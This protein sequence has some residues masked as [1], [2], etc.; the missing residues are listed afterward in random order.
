MPMGPAA[1]V[2]DLVAHA[3]PPVLTG[4]PGST[5]VLIGNQPAW[6]GLTAAGAAALAKAAAEL[7]KDL[8]K[9]L[10]SAAAGNAKAPKDIADAVMDFGKFMASLGPDMH[11]CGLSTPN[12]HGPGMV[13]DGSQTVLI[14]NMSACRLGDT[15]IEAGPPNKIAF[16][17]P[18][19]H[20]GDVGMGGAGT[21]TGQCMAAAKAAGTPFIEPVEPLA[22]E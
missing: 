2:G 8:V 16:G 17:F 3:T 12:P 21:N 5:N 4:G 15:L 9:L 22:E 19:V 10:A 13:V 6:R 18:T 20:I 7:A 14:N 1:R 11:A